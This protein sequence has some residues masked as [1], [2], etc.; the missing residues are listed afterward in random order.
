M[1]ELDARR[2]SV[3]S[4][5]DAPSRAGWVL[6]P[7]LTVRDPIP[8][9]NA[10]DRAQVLTDLAAA[11]IVPSA[12]EPIFF[13][14]AD[15]GTGRELEYT[16][17]GTTFHTV[18]AGD[19]G[20]VAATYN[21]SWNTYT[22]LKTRLVGGAQLSLTGL[23]RP[24]TGTVA[25]GGTTS[26]ATLAAGHRPTSIRR[27]DGAGWVAGGSPGPYKGDCVVEVIGGT[28]V[29]NIYAPEIKSGIYIDVTIGM[30]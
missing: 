18:I 30:D 27:F 13:F 7:L 9:A 20:W 5:G 12:S 14:R 3:P 19:T 24:N 8:V 28:G 6:G 10:T 16:T 2:H 4:G 21:A 22:T 29:V 11:G 23:I 1:S 15:A 26:V 17:N 25:A